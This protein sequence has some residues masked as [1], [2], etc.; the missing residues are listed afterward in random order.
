MTALREE[1]A[2]LLGYPRVLRSIQHTDTLNALI[3]LVA[4]EIAAARK[5]ALE[6]AAKCVES[7]LA[8]DAPL[9]PIERYR[10][11]FIADAIREM[12]E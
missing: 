6:E 10:A 8:D 3:D 4:R 9:A 5:V 12:G 2:R 7:G 1:L 11:A